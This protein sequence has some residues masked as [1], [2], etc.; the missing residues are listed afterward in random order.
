MAHA[1]LTYRWE[2]STGG[3]GANGGTVGGGGIKVI[4]VADM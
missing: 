2:V 1:Y 3:D 4:P